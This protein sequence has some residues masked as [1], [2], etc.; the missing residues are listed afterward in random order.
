M[1]PPNHY[2]NLLRPF[3]VPLPSEVRFNRKVG[4]IGCLY[5]AKLIAA[6]ASNLLSFGQEAI[7][8]QSFF[9]IIRKIEKG[10]IQKGFEEA[11]HIV[12]GEH[13]DQFI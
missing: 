3:Q 7:E 8:K 11:D 12:E 6:T 4:G 2:G 5:R 10:N 13:E 1:N 9:D